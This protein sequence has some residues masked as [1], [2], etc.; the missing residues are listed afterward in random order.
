MGMREQLKLPELIEAYICKYNEE[1][2]QLAAQASATSTRL[3]TKRDRIEA[4][5]SAQS[6]FIR[7]V[8]A[9]EDAKQRIA[10]LKAQ[11][12]QIEAKLAPSRRHHRTSLSTLQPWS[13]TSKRSM[14]FQRRWQTTQQ[15]QTTVGHSPKIF[16]R[17]FT[18]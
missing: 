2:R 7:S 11:R 18:A 12:L 13:A 14:L 5:A 3:E 6:T 8:I 9:E 15:P 16:G 4:N 17:L 1:R 10:K